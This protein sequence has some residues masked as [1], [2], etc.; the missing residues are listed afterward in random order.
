[1]KI[2]AGIVG[3][4]DLSG[5]PERARKLEAEGYDGIGSAELA[6]D[7]FLPLVLAAEHTERVELSTSIAVAFARNPMTVALQAHDLHAYS[8]GR[9]VLGLGSQIRPH[10]EKRFGMPW[11]RPAARMREFVLAL[12][13]IWD[14]W[15]NG[16]PLCFEGEFYRHTLMTPMFVPPERGYGAPRVFLAAV[17]PRMTEAAAE[18]ADGLIAHAFTTERYLRAVTLPAVERGLARA[19]RRRED[20]EICAP[21]FVRAAGDES[22]R[23]VALRRQIAFY[24]STPAYRPVLALHGWGEMQTELNRMSKRGEWV[25]MGRLIE[26]DVLDAFCLS[27]PPEGFADELAGRFGGLIDRFLGVPPIDDPELR[28]EQIARLQAA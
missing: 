13:A 1:M 20:F 26:G 18:V 2:D 16:E 11:S 15:Y 14:C 9:F 6:S 24:G 22:E 3:E 21:L 8:K 27:A 25:E 7:P 19:G 17:G 4:Y 23:V 28:A 10:I 12:R 5:V